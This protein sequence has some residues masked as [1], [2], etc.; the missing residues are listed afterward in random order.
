MACAGEDVRICQE[1]LVVMPMYVCEVD[2]G[3]YALGGGR[4]HL[5]LLVVQEM[6]CVC[7]SRWGCLGSR[8]GVLE[9]VVR[10]CVTLL[11]FCW[12]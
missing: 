6:T 7:G 10:S 2:S 9:L 8:C 12:S 1:A 11:Q 4:C 5:G 3:L